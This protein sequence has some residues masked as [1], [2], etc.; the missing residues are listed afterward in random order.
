MFINFLKPKIEKLKNMPRNINGSYSFEKYKVEY[1]DPVSFYYEYKDIFENKIYDFKAVRSNP[2]II[3]A[4]GCIG[5]SVLYFKKIYPDCTIRVFEPDPII[6][7]VLEKNIKNNGFENVLLVNAGLGKTEETINFYSDGSDGG[8]MYKTGEVN[9]TKVKVVRLSQYL[10]EK[11]DFLKMNIEG[12]EGDVFEEIEDKLINVREIIFEYHAFDELPQNLGKI[13]NI[14]D[15]Q[16][17]RYIV[18]DATNAKIPVP[19]S[20]DKNYKYFNLVYAKN[21]NWQ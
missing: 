20:L 17:F 9:E 13:L 10:N 16:N 1:T 2:L 4:G 3:D 15:R 8:S 7:S 12:M 19:F 11:I 21:L 14:F 5:M 6:F 18:T